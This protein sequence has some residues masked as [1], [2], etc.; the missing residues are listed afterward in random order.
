MCSEK[1]ID[2]LR[3]YH[4]EIKLL[5]KYDLK[6]RASAAEDS[7]KKTEKAISGKKPYKKHSTHLR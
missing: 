5:V 6:N 4:D 1:P 3:I 7:E 2:S